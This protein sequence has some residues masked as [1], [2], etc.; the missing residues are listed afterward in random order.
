MGVLEIEW[1]FG[2]SKADK[3]LLWIFATIVYY[4]WQYIKLFINNYTKFRSKSKIPGFTRIDFKKCV[5]PFAFFFVVGPFV[6][7]IFLYKYIQGDLLLQISI[8][9]AFFLLVVFLIGFIYLVYRMII[10]FV[11]SSVCLL[12]S[13]TVT[14][15]HAIRYLARK[16]SI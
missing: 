8:F 10:D 7:A 3:I 2:K 14:T 12:R 9:Y 1:D 5:Y 11:V 16:K 13:F 15:I 4:V 6:F